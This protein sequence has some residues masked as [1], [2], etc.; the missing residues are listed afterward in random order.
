MSPTKGVAE[1][2][3]ELGGRPSL[4]GVESALQK[5]TTF[6][7]KVQVCANDLTIVNRAMEQEVKEGKCSNSS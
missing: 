4:S 7:S 2:Q 3:E 1:Y 6:E 5:G